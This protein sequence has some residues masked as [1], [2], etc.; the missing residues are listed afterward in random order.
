MAN[1][2]KPANLDFLFSQLI[3]NF[4]HLLSRKQISKQE[5]A[6]IVKQNYD[7]K[8]PRTALF[9]QSIFRSNFETIGLNLYGDTILFNH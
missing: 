8:N 3:I 9:Y 7:V 6:Q 1:T 4:S 5:F 2:N